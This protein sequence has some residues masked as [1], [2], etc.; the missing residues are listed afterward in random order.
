MLDSVADSGMETGIRSDATPRFTRDQLREML[1]ARGEAQEE[2]FS[3]ARE[4][5]RLAGADEVKLRGVI[6]LTNYCQKTC[7]YC[8][9]RAGNKALDRYRMTEDNIMALAEGIREAGIGTVFLQGGQD[10]KTDKLISSIIPRIRSELDCEVLLCMGEKPRAIYEEWAALGATSYILKFESSSPDLYYQVVRTSLAKRIDCIRWIKAAG[11]EIGTGNI[12]GLP[13]QT[14]EHL[15]DDILLA[16]ELEPDFVSSSPFIP[17]EGT[18]LETIDEGDV[19]ATLNTMA[20]YRI[21]FPRAL[22]PTVSALEKLRGGGQLAGL[23]AGANVITIN[24]TPKDFRE[25]YAIYS[26]KNRFIV[27][28][29][30]ARRIIEEAGLTIRPAH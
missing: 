23:Q 17:N 11:M 2:L 1:L 22:V 21:L 5:R 10:P 7:D 13:G 4:A 30:H 3:R 6:E 12:V 19:D 20:I 28:G 29:G 25:R 14:L 18:P 9:I 15:I 8:A 16:E 26:A 24:F 27:S